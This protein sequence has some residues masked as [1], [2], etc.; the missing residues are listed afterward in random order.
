MNPLGLPFE[1]YDDF[2]HFRKEE[3]LEYPENI[4]K[5]GTMKPIVP[6]TYKTVPVRVT[7]RLDGTGEPALDGD[8]TDALDLIGRLTKSTRVR[9]SVIRHAFR[10]Y[11]GRNEMLSDSKTLIDADQGMSRAAA[12]TKRSSFHS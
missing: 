9:Q 6:N 4:I 11:M 8:V 7:G 5:Q 3:A 12:A 2:G 1:M 10:Y